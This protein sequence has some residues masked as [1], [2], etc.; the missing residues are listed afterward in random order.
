MK[1][2]YDEKWNPWTADILDEYLYFVCPECDFKHQSREIFIG[3]ALEHHP[4]SIECISKIK[5]KEEITE[6]NNGGVIE[7]L[8]TI[9]KIY[10]MRMKIWKIISRIILIMS[11]QIM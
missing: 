6:L 3:H 8:L 7:T 2:D 9:L 5:V 10:M 4:K 1:S 11:C